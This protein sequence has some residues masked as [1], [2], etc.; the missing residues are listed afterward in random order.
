[1]R[2]FLVNNYS[3]EKAFLLWEKGVSGSHHVWGKVELDR[4]GKVDII[5]FP[6]EKFKFLNTIGKL[7]GISHLDQQIRILAKMRDFDVI[8]APYSL[9]NTKLLV[10][11]K[12]F[13]LFRKP[14]VA[15]VHQPFLFS[16]SSN[17]LLRWIS[18]KVLMQFESVVF[19]SEPLLNDTVTRLGISSSNRFQFS[20]AQWGPDRQFY[21]RFNTDIPLEECNY[22][23]SAGHTDRDYETIIEAFRGINFHLKIF[24]TRN[25]MPKVDSLPPNVEIHSDFIPYIELLNHYLYARVILIPLIYPKEKEGCQGM[26]GLQDVLA[27]NKPVIITENPYLNLNV[28]TE[29]IGLMVAK[30]DVD[31]WREAINGLVHDWD[32]LKRMQ[33][34]TKEIL[35]KKVN[36]E[37]F[38]LKLEKVLLSQLQE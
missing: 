21:K 27:F 26:T 28:E 2:V 6:H 1:M 35:E 14:I 8:Y 16:R 32:R 25:S 20:T 38:A 18:K 23:I 37:V 33:S 3:M 11:L 7:F 30:R 19:L 17:S 24:C 5:L 29:G 31:G 15:V 12:F 13:R 34:K 4:R 9:A 22:V 36:S 10:L